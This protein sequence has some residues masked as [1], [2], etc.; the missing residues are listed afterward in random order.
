MLR[1]ASGP[2]ETFQ[3]PAGLLV[4]LAGGT[5]LLDQVT[6]FV[7]A[8]F[9]PLYTHQ[10]VVPGFFNLV[11]VR[12]TG[13]AFSFLAGSPTL[14][15]QVFFI[16]VGVVAAGALL[17][18]YRTTGGREKAK[19]AALALILGGAL[20]NLVDRLRLGAV[21]DFLDFHIGP[22]HWPAFNV[23]DSAIT[24]GAGILL[25]SILRSR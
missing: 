22:Y 6:K 13:A 9:L 19:R 8:R 7:I 10:E 1:K 5:L 3:S 16:G 15:R 21:V 20:G 11:H 24:V 23:A 12:N 4:A 17:Y 14:G 25:I 2:K 18:L